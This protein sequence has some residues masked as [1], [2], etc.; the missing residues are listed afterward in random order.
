MKDKVDF[1]CDILVDSPAGNPDILVDSPA[2]NPDSIVDF[3]DESIVLETN[4][5]SEEDIFMVVLSSIEKYKQKQFNG[6]KIKLIHNA[7]ETKNYVKYTKK[8]NEITN[9]LINII[10]NNIRSQICL[11]ILEN[12]IELIL[13]PINKYINFLTVSTKEKD[14]VDTEICIIASIINNMYDELIAIITT[15][16][17]KLSDLSDYADSDSSDD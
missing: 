5:F 8:L 6:I 14:I 4:A 10:K 2:G 1:G 9:H 12:D 13:N 15:N 3:D 16:Y 7:E 11:E 17:I